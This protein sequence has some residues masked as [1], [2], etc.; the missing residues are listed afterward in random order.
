MGLLNYMLNHQRVKSV[1]HNTVQSSYKEPAYKKFLVIRIWFLFP[2]MYQGTSLK[3]IYKVLRLQG[4][5]F[6]GPYDFFISRLYYTT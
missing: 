3:Y 4:I 5:D 6:Y 2:N 1:K